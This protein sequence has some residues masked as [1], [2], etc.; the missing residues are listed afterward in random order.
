MESAAHTSSVSAVSYPPGPSNDGLSMPRFTE[1]WNASFLQSGTVTDEAR[2]FTECL[3]PCGAEG[4]IPDSM[5]ASSS[6][7]SASGVA[8][9]ASTSVD[10]LG[11][12]HLTTFGVTDDCSHHYP[13]QTILYDRTDF[14]IASDPMCSHHELSELDITPIPPSF[15][16]LVNWKSPTAPCCPLGQKRPRDTELD[17][18][19]DRYKRRRMLELRV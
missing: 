7:A 14:A 11:L 6:S 16:A 13:M 18:L 9:T 10:S 4:D 19:A 2:Y 5:V 8:S 1:P 3:D 12:H 17:E 15:G